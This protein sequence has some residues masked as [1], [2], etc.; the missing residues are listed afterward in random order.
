MLHVAVAY[1]VTSETFVVDAVNAADDAGWEAWLVALDIENRARF[2][3][4]PDER[5]IRVPGFSPAR[6]A[7][8]RLVR[9]SGTDR[10][11]RSVLRMAEAAEPTLLHAHFGW[12]ALYALPLARMLDVPLVCTFH[13]SDVTVF[14]QR[15]SSPD[16]VSPTY[17][18]LF[19]HL[20]QA[21]AVS[22][23]IARE[24]RDLGWR[25]PTE[26]IPAGVSLE[27]FPHR[28][29]P[30]ARTAHACCSSGA[31][32]HARGWMFCFVRLRP[33]RPDEPT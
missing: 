3:N 11:A 16:R 14:P 13:A 17:R 23:F 8:D 19:A 10:F 18:A 20:A 6:R 24:V 28:S 7:R 4:P 1:G 9:R 26:V 5:I 30:P 32:F 33:W 2:P 12:A 22:A 15:P 27:R 31:S 25:G 29:E 21:L